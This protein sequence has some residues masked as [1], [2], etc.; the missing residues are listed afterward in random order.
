MAIGIA[1]TF[2]S[3]T[4]IKMPAT[5]TTLRNGQTITGEETMPII[6][7]TVN[8]RRTPEFVELGHGVS[9]AEA[10]PTW[11]SRAKTPTQAE[12]IAHIF[13]D[14]HPQPQ[15]ETPKT[16]EATGQ[17]ESTPSNPDESSPFD[18]LEIETSN[19]LFYSTQ[20]IKPPKMVLPGLPEGTI[21]SLAAAPGCGKSTAFAQWT[22]DGAAG[23]PILGIFET[24]RP[25]KH[26]YIS[27]EELQSALQFRIVDAF[28]RLPEEYK[29][30]VGNNAIARSFRGDMALF[31]EDRTIK[32]TP[33]W[34]ALLRL[35]DKIQ[36]EVLLLDHWGKFIT[37]ENEANNVKIQEACNIIDGECLKRN[38]TVVFAAHIT[39]ANARLV[40]K[41]EDLTNSLDATAQKGGTALTGAVRWQCNMAMLSQVYAGKKIG[42]EAAQ[43]RD[44]SFVATKI[45]K[46][47]Y[48]PLS[49]TFFFERKP[50]SSF[51]E[52]A[53]TIRI[54]TR[55]ASIDADVD[56]LIQ[57]VRK[58]KGQGLP[59]F[60]W[61]KGIAD[62]PEYS[63][64]DSQTWGKNRYYKAR[65]TA[66][67]QGR[68]TREKKDKGNGE[69]LVEPLTHNLFENTF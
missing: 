43:R 32:T 47:N 7:Q 58:R 10:D 66:E 49:D 53:N 12:Q 67:A 35:L 69:I 55:K 68:L 19:A 54:E 65:D 57:M 22:I 46:V 64:Q 31:K 29:D 38:I 48:G 18:T 20:E 9:G 5:D 25:R 30:N 42:P 51:L 1:R 4:E 17:K 52:V 16:T 6:P 26:L 3:R 2:G 39:K 41:E 24:D 45:S 40:Q 13:Q 36:P 50:G 62:N 63:T 21:A 27:A 33:Q 23:R 61:T 14:D 60:S 15:P 34:Y 44:G 56:H 28:K 37:L 59:P 8:V 11:A